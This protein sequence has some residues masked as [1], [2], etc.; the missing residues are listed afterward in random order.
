MKEYIEERVLTIADYIIESRA[1]VR[2]AAKRFGVSKSTVHKDMVDRLREINPSLSQDVRRVL[3]V[4]KQ[5][6]HLRGGMATREKYL[7]MKG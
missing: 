7:H 6:R 2:E 3:D 1:T 4:N 5:E